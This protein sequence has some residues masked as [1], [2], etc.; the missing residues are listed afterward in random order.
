V[1]WTWDDR[2]VDIHNLEL[3][4][5][6]GDSIVGG[7]PPG[8][9]NCSW[10][11]PDSLNPCSTQLSESFDYPS[12]MFS[13]DYQLND[14]TLVYGKTSRASKA[15]GW[16]LRVGSIPA[17]DPEELTDIEFGI[18][19]DVTENL[20]VNA[21]YFHSWTKDVQRSKATVIG[22]PPAS[23]AFIVNAGEIEIDGFELEV[24]T[25][26]WEGM[27]LSF[28]GSWMEGAYKNGSFT[29][30]QAVP[31][32]GFWE[33]DRSD[34]EMIQTPEWQFGVNATQRIP[35]EKGEAIIYLGYKW[36]DEQY[37]ETLTGPTGLEAISPQLQA[38]LDALYDGA[39]DLNKVDSYG[40][41]NGS[42]ALNFDGGYSVSLWGNNLL[43][44]EYFSRSYGDFYTTLGFAMA[45]VGEPR[46]F[47]INAKYSF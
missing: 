22:D 3:I 1:R 10:P 6:P 19:A 11:N 25:N 26:L 30:T 39:Q 38:G 17:F 42:L 31:G 40:L 18:K 12:W 27:E 37:F 16:N 2:E 41:L 23:T 9:L 20:R 43:D 24:L 33:V 44:E 45:F 14:S 7:A 36:I 32:V 21:A 5:A 15:G 4:G 34:E 13:L 29:E 46:T 8:Q 28:N 35:F 47:G